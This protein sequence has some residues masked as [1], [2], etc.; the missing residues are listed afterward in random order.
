MTLYLDILLL[1]LYL[2]WK[3]INF[4]SWAQIDTIMLNNRGK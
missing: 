3:H 2:I 1:E 4:E